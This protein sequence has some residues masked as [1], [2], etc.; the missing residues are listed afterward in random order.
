MA[1]HDPHSVGVDHVLVWRSHGL[2]RHEVV[3]AVNVPILRPF[4]ALG[5][6][7]VSGAGCSQFSGGV[8]PTHRQRFPNVAEQDDAFEVSFQEAKKPHELSVVVP[9]QVGGGFA[10]KMQV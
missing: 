9:K 7:R 1:H 2:G 5:D 3:I 10:S 6:L 4:E 8:A